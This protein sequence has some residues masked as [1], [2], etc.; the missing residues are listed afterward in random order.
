MYLFGLIWFIVSFCTSF[1]VRKSG[2]SEAILSV[3]VPDCRLM[4]VGLFILNCNF[5]FVFALSCS[6]L[7]CCSFG[8]LRELLRIV[9]FALVVEC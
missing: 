9:F 7:L 6:C 1:V 2:F 3:F 5:L 4:V 8:Q